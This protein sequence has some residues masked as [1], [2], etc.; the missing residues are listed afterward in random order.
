MDWISGVNCDAVGT[1]HLSCAKSLRCWYD[2]FDEATQRSL[3][4]GFVQR[5]FSF[6]DS[7]RRIII[8][9]VWQ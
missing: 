1:I 2:G 6:M 5:Y 3:A 7:H 9:P 4:A 8:Y